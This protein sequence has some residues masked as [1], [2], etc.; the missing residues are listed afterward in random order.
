MVLGHPSLGLVSLVFLAGA[1]VLTFFIILAGVSTTTPLDK[2]YFLRADTSLITGARSISQW[3]YFYICSPGNVDCT[4]ASPA[5]P[6]GH[7]WA[8]SAAG[9]PDGLSGGF[10]G[11]TTSKYYFYM[12]RFGW[13][14]YLI[15]L[16]FMVTAF[17]TG[18]LACCGRLGSA[19][20]GFTSLVALFFYS[21]AASLMT[22]TF[23]KAR[24]A[25][26]HDGRDA[27][28][29]RYAFGFTWGAWAALFIA[30]VLFCLGVRSRNDG[31]SDRRGWRRRRSTRSR[32]S[33]DVGSKRVKDDYS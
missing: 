31:V 25:F 16:F 5:M 29:G 27:S 22:A 24:D 19:I 11:H 26:K 3:T 9:V 32:R 30:S 18:F 1:L 6:F 23:V 17:F 12:W 20:S 7:A 28:I 33:Y 2:T 13:V 21:V 10:A 4:K 8:D 15:S 14:F